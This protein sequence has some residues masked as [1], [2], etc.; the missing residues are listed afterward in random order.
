MDL[1]VGKRKE[2]GMAL[3]RKRAEGSVDIFDRFFADWPEVWRRPLMVFTPP[4]AG[5]LLRVDE[6]QE[7]GTRV[8]KAELPGID[9]EHDVEVTVDNGVLHITAE[10]RQEEKVEDKEYYRRELRYG[11][12]RRDLPL[13]EGVTEADVKAT[14]KDG[15]LEIRVPLPKEVETKSVATKVP[16]T[17]A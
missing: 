12:F 14:Y 7:D 10:H 1:S 8:I 2:T 16:V 15:L 17:T 9:P 3:V 13:P 4:D 11:S 6:F 5:N